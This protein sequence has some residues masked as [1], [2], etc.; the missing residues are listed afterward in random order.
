M[1]LVPILP[2]DVESESLKFAAATTANS[3][4]YWGNHVLIAP[5]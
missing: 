1:N 3:K 4:F 2:N 5:I